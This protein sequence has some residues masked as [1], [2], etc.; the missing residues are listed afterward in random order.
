MQPIKRFITIAILF[1]AL[2]SSSCNNEANKEKTTT[3]NKKEQETVTESGDTTSIS[4]QDKQTSNTRKRELDF[5]KAYNGKYPADVN[6]LS[7]PVLKPRLVKLLADRYAFVKETWA[8][9]SPMEIK[10]NYFIASACQAHNCGN[11]NFIIVADLEKNILYAGV[12][13]ENKVMKYAEDG[14]P[15]PEINKWASD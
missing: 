6:L 14:S 15:N 4:Q 5:L 13:E 2:L 10:N 12:R 1:M 3:D 8:V 11:T 9:E 7:D